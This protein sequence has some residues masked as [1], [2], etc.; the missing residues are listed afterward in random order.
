MK[1]IQF[2]AVDIWGNS[3]GERTI[4]IGSGTVNA[5]SHSN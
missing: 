3:L 4:E 2:Q 5:Y 1:T